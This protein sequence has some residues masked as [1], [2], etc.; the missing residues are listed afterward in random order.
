MDRPFTRLAPGN[1][2]EFR[3]ARAGFHRIEDED[4]AGGDNASAALAAQTRPSSAQQQQQQEEEPQEQPQQRVTPAPL[5][6]SAST[7][8]HP[9]PATVSLPPPVVPKPATAAMP[10]LLSPSAN[11]LKRIYRAKGEEIERLGELQRDNSAKFQPEE[12]RKAACKIQH[13]YRTQVAMYTAF[14][15]MMFSCKDGRMADFGTISFLSGSRTAKFVRIADT[16]SAGDLSHFMEKYWHLPRPDVVLSVTG[17]AASLQLT[18]T[19]Q[20]V[21]DRGI[22]TAAAMT[23]AW[24]FTGGTDSGVMKLVGEALYKYGLEVPLV[25]IAPWGAVQGKRALHG[26]KG[27]TYNYRGGPPAGHEAK[28]NPYHTHQLLVDS[29]AEYPD[30]ALAWGHEIEMRSRLERCYATTKGV[31]VVL[32]VVQGGIGTLDTMIAAANRGRRC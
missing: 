27:E 29:W 6:V 19:L 5:D 16:T 18:A 2:R 12:Q 14:G 31:P 22:A 13:W 23:N 25:G 15:P 11:R 4:R 3:Q 21:F 24:I 9:P 28:L 8:S 20:R 30:G 17:S 26:A 32:L 7:A 10:G 1:L